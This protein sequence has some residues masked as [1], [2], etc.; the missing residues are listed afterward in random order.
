M[1]TEDE[2]RQGF[3]IGDWEV[4]PLRGVLRN[5]DQEERP[6]PRALGLV[7]AWEAL[8][9]GL[10]LLV[11]LL[12]LVAELSGAVAPIDAELGAAPLL[13]TVAF[14]LIGG[15]GVAAGWGVWRRRRWAWMLTLVV[16]GFAVLQLI[17]A[18]ASGGFEGIVQTG[19]VSAVAALAIF[20]YLT[21]PHVAAAFG[22]R[23]R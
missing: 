12:V 11:G 16:Q 7:G 17:L 22:R 8:S 18:V 5:G 15:I 21:R 9:G 1:L 2:L 6:E 13:V 20:Y 14:L 3:T 10:V 23:V 19:I 4:L